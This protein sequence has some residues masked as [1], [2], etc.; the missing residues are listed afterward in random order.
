MRLPSSFKPFFGGF[1]M[2]AEEDTK[3]CPY[4]GET[5]KRMAVKC[6]WC[7][8]V[9]DE[10][11]AEARNPGR[12]EAEVSEVDRWL[13]P[14]GR[15]GWAIAAGYLGLLAMFPLLGL[16]CGIGAVFTGFRALRDCREHPRL[17]GRGRAIF[18]IVMGIIFGLINA[19]GVAMFIYYEIFK[20]K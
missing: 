8:T 1:S 11:E 3:A 19:A 18:G 16:L 12:S 17:G 15:S 14:V 6:R 2:A 10:E 4:C 20:K 5:I 7:G 13:M 9:L